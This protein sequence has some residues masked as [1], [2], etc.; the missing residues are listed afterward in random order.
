[1]LGNS[2]NRSWAKPNIRRLISEAKRWVRLVT[3]SSSM[4]MRPEVG[5]SMHPTRASRVVLPEPLG[6]VHV[7]VSSQPAVDGLPKQ[8]RKRQTC[9][10][11]TRIGQVLLDQFAETQAFIQFPH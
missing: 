2:W 6:V 11:P 3:S 8:I 7:F 5:R 4:K 1:M 9:V 10:R